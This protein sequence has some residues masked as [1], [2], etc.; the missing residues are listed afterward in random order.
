M[1]GCGVLAL[2]LADDGCDGVDG[3]G[4]R[5]ES[6][7]EMEGLDLASAVEDMMSRKR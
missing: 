5:A 1:P 2:A 6:E 7:A 4:M 3:D